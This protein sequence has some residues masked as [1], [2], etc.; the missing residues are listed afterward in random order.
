MQVYVCCGNSVS[1]ALHLLL[2]KCEM[3]SI[4]KACH[5][6]VTSHRECVMA[7]VK[8]FI[9]PWW[10]MSRVSWWRKTLLLIPKQWNPRK[11]QSI[12]MLHLVYVYHWTHQGRNIL[13]SLPAVWAHFHP[14]KCHSFSLQACYC[15]QVQAIRKIHRCIDLRITYY[16]CNNS[17]SH[18]L[19]N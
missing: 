15:G 14:Q 19:D 11:G 7:P 10:T 2:F 5:Q 16:V 6:S 4:F 17:T 9:S 12:E 1:E 18:S 13:F 8:L 3:A